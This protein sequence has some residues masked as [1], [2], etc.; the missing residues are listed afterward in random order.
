MNISLNV[1]LRITI[2]IVV[3][4][5]CI[6]KHIFF[7]FFFSCIRSISYCEFFY[8]SVT[9]VGSGGEPRVKNEMCGFYYR[10]PL[11]RSRKRILFNTPA[12]I[13]E[14]YSRGTVCELKFAF[15]FYFLLGARQILC[16]RALLLS[17]VLILA[18]LIWQKKLVTIFPGSYIF[19][20][21]KLY[22]FL[23]RYI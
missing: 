10:R 21:D 2:I 1:R 5:G 7:Y 12:D 6:S 19:Y 18:Q 17:Y 4:T 13:T 23:N 14:F 3:L 20:T 15:S 16:R 11:C 8:C 22:S 9:G